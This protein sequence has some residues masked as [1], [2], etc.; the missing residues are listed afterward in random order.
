MCVD[1]GPFKT[2]S[3]YSEGCKEKCGR[4]SNALNR[5]LRGKQS[6]SFHLNTT[7]IKAFAIKNSES[8][9]NLKFFNDYFL[10]TVRFCY[11]S[12]CV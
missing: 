6:P 11:F 3:F 7:G 12:K 2:E 8:K 5:D 4:T 10:V 1:L 9:K